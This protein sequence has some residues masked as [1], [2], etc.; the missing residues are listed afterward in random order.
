MNAV[1]GEVAKPGKR[2]GN[3]GVCKGKFFIQLSTPKKS[4]YLS[5]GPVHEVRHGHDLRLMEILERALQ[6]DYSISWGRKAM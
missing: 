4:N 1:D 5:A 6:W 2:A 3:Y